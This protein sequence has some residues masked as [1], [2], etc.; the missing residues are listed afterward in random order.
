MQLDR[1]YQDDSLAVETFA[2]RWFEAR[3]AEARAAGPMALN[4]FAVEV[5]RHLPAGMY[6]PNQDNDE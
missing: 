4:H 3:L 1:A 5:Q 2:R 6:P